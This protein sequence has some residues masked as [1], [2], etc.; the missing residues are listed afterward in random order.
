MCKWRWKEFSF[1]LACLRTAV[2]TPV[3]SSESLCLTS[4][5]QVSLLLWF[6]SHPEPR[7]HVLWDGPGILGSLPVWVTTSKCRKLS[8]MILFKMYFLSCH[9][10]LTMCPKIFCNGYRTQI[11][12]KS[13][14]CW[15]MP[16]KCNRMS[17]FLSQPFINYG[18]QKHEF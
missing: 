8:S 17:T 13:C 16:D 18:T 1:H 12:M 4:Y 14:L 6:T 11:S 7:K 9:N 15:Q 3:A 2:T 5:R 10:H